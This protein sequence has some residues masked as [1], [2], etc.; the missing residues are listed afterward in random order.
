MALI[1][2]MWKGPVN[3]SDACAG[4]DIAVIPRIQVCCHFQC[5]KEAFHSDVINVESCMYDGLFLAGRMGR[6][7]AKRK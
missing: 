7:A 4:V 5:L 3:H 2:M 1:L 6:A